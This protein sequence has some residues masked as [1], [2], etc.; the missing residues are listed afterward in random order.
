[1][2]DHN[3]D[4]DLK[5]LWQSTPPIDLDE[6]LGH[7][8]AERRRMR[9]LIWF[10]TAGTFFGLGIL[11][12]YYKIGWLTSPVVIV[13]IAII[14][15]VCQ[16]WMWLWRRGQWNAVSQAPLDLLELQLKR[17]RTGLK[18]G[19]YYAWGTPI[20]VVAGVLSVQILPIEPAGLPIS[21]LTRFGLL[22]VLL[23]LMAGLTWFG[24]RLIRRS[25]AQIETLEPR[26]EALRE[27]ANEETEN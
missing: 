12:L 21:T 1:M 7:V 17:A 16:A 24:V 19:R 5:A 13:T 10:E 18:I 20:S 22:F 15:T 26:I 6:L 27:S 4:L 25:R 8:D 23:F 2:T 3:D 11:A 9:N 14:A